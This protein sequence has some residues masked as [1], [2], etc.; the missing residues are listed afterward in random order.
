MVEK[1]AAIIN[2]SKGLLNISLVTIAA[3]ASASGNVWLAGATAIPGALVSLDTLRPLLEKK[4]EERL[5]LPIPA[6]W[7]QEPLL[8]SWQ[9]ACSCVE[10]HLPEVIKGVE[11]QLH[12]ETDYPSPSRI[13]QIFAE[14]VSQ[15][16]SPWV[17]QSQDHYMVAGYVAPL[18]LEKFA[19]SLKAVIDTVKED[20]L[21]RQ[22]TEIV[23][24][25]HTIQK[26]HV[27]TVSA[28][29]T[30][31]A[32]QDALAAA[33]VKDT[34]NAPSI[35]IMLEQKRQSSNYDVYISYDEAD[36]IEVMG[37]GEKLKAQGLLPWFDLLETRPG[38]PEM[39][40]QEEQVLNIP[41]STVF[42]GQNKMI[43]KQQ[44]QM[45]SF[46]GQFIERNLPVIPVI[47]TN[48][49]Q[50]LRLHLIL[51]TLGVSIFAVLSL[52]RWNN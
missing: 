16:L 34:Q 42:V 22:L 32:T 46:I 41:I 8:Q 12:K 43:G 44:L 30:N 2:V 49:P 1:K 51:E 4:Q 38:T 23:N 11:E 24:T 31:S 7:T 39:R 18:L 15:Y 26:S 13:E 52:I 29:P 10:A 27:I 37:I 25:L 9:S 40:Q 17:V 21:T 19:K 36:E 20:A 14:Q 33:I 5:E 28:V 3:M 35:A 47:L 50:D 45:Y 48:A 6:W